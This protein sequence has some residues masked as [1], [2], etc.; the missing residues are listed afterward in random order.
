[1]R[2][3][4]HRLLL[5]ASE[6]KKSQQRCSSDNKKI[7]LTEVNGYFALPAFMRPIRSEPVR[8]SEKTL[9]R[10]GCLAECPATGRGCGSVYLAE[11]VAEVG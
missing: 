3:K 7:F 1:M 11:T 5:I 8:R 10:T 2:M 9:R 4:L 6:A